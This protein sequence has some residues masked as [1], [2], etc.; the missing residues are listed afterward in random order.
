MSLC[1]LPTIPEAAEIKTDEGRGWLSDEMSSYLTELS[2]QHSVAPG[3]AHA[4]LSSIK[5]TVAG[6]STAQWVL[7]AQPTF[8]GDLLSEGLNPAQLGGSSSFDKLLEKR[9][10]AKMALIKAD[11]DQRLRRAL[12]RRYAG[13]NI[14]FQAGQLCFYWRDGR[15]ADLAKIR[16]LGPAKG[17]RRED[18]DSGKPL[19]YWVATP[20]LRASPCTS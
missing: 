10:A 8:P 5:P 17:V 12:L 11:Q 6:Y 19:L 13:L 18:D 9:A 20:T 16:W 1:C 15:A 7:G 2:I 14:P 4:R 3:E